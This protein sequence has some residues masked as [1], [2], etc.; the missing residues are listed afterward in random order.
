[1]GGQDKGLIEVGGRPLI[2][3]IIEALKPQVDSI[4]ISANRNLEQYRRYGYPVVEDMMGEFFGPLVGMA[5]A[6]QAMDSE[7]LMTVPC[8]SPFVPPILAEKLLLALRDGQ[9]DISVAHDS[10]RMQPVFALLRAG[11]LPSLLAYLDDGGRKIDTWYAEHRLVKAD[12]SD[13]PDTFLNINTPDDKNSV[14]QKMKRKK[15]PAP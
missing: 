2:E 10:L 15:V 9:A 6:M 5:S 13:W 7:Y 11:L 12:F 14:E 8:D 3:Y 1:M 4:L